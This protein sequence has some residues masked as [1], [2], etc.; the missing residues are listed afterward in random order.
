MPP[1]RPDG[2]IGSVG[3][4]AAQRVVTAHQP[5]YLP[6]P[7]LFHKIALADTFVIFDDVLYDDRDFINRNRIRGPDGPLWLTVP[8]LESPGLRIADARIRS[9]LPWRRKHHN[10]ILHAYRRAPHAPRYLPFFA[11]LYGRDWQRLAELDRFCLEFFLA[12]LDIRVDILE[13]S[14]MAI[15]TRKSDL[16]LDVCRATGADLFLFGASGRDYADQDAF[17]RAGVAVEFQDYRHPEYDQGG[18]F[19]SHLSIVDLLVH[20]GPASREVLM[21]DN[22]SRADLVGKHFAGGSP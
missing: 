1:D 21:A 7:G 4:A 8:I 18:P 3:V 6:W 13:L 17:R 16:V 14:A 11:E 22:L 5:T 19:V 10:S 12:E 20:C 2:T 9:D 15:Q